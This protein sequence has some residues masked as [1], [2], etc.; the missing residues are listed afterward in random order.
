M[1]ETVLE[2]GFRDGA[3]AFGNAVE[4]RELGLHVGREGGMGRGVDVNCPGSPFLHVQTDPVLAQLDRCARLAQLEH[5][6]IEQP[7]MGVP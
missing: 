7:R 5:Y 6:G 2:N 1:H 3:D 4:G